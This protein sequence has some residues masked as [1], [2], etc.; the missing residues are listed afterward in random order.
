MFSIRP[1]WRTLLFSLPLAPLTETS[2]PGLTYFLCPS[3]LFVSLSSFH[4]HRVISSSLFYPFIFSLNPHRYQSLYVVALSRT[5]F[6][7]PPQRLSAGS[8]GVVGCCEYSRVD[9]WGGLIMAGMALPLGSPTLT[10]CQCSRLD[11]LCMGA[12]N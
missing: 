7:P 11:W 1:R 4:I 2:L 10:Q 8:S 12:S 5:T 3:I 6:P 9:E